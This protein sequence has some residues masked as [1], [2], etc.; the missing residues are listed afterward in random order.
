[1]TGFGAKAVVSGWFLTAGIGDTDV[2]GGWDG[3][4]GI[5]VAGNPNDEWLVGIDDGG[6]D[7]SGGT[8][9]E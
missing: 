7:G 2:E 5:G 6:F 8:E 4:G 9:V 3:G 1:M